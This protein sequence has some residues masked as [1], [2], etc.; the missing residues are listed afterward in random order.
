[1]PALQAT[2]PSLIPA[3]KGD[4]PAGR[5]RSRASRGLVITQMALSIVLLV[6]AGLFLRDLKAAVSVN[7]GFVSD[8]L[9][10]ADLDP[11][12]QGYTRSRSED[13]YRQL[14]ERTRVLPG[15]HGVG[16]TDE[17]PLGLNENDSEAKI[18]GYTPAANENMS[19]QNAAVTPGYFEAMGIPLLAGRGFATRDDS[20]APGVIV[21]NQRAVDR[22]WHGQDPIGRVVHMRGRDH[23][24]I[25]VVPTGKYQRLG[26]A[27][28][29]FVFVAQAQHWNAAMSML[30]RTVDDP[31]KLVRVL[32]AEVAA[33]DA[34]LPVS[35]VRTM[36]DH[37][38]IALLPARL[39]GAALGVFGLLGLV[40]A[41]VG[42][43]GVMSYSV[44]Q[45][46]RE[47]GIRMAIGA[48]SGDVVSLV[49]RQGL[50]LVLIGTTLGL[51]GAIA[52]SR[53]LRGILYGN[54]TGDP[55]TF[56]AVPLLLIGVALLATW[57]PA[58]RA[59]AVDPLLALRQE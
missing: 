5:S 45:R 27:P 1:M 51:A 55:L 17:V 13:F 43:Y 28:T 10:I 16:F 25:G 12:L 9:L 2:N 23:T 31:E 30:V 46:R 37:L 58:R 59:S 35:D 19:I 56:V 20:A 26:E 54:G 21:V 7:K 3:L 48:K 4:A 34:N 42:M 14:S 6:C 33:L 24:V 40:L 39:S 32:R 18:P 47:I 52:A 36:N 15:V 38:A 44:S 11:G 53:L 29:T 41:S 50:T 49:M 8:N 22:F 57:I